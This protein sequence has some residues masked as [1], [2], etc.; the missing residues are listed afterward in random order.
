[1][2]PTCGHLLKKRDHVFVRSFFALWASVAEPP[3]KNPGGGSRREG[4]SPP[5]LGDFYWG[6]TLVFVGPHLVDSGG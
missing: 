1:M 5:R 3:K 4:A 2:N 6:L